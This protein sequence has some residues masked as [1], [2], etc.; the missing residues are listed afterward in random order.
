MT[1][2]AEMSTL[3]QRLAEFEAFFQNKAR[4]QQRAT[5]SKTGLISALRSAADSLRH[6]FTEGITREGLTELFRRETRETLQF[7]TRQ[8]DFA[9]LRSLPWFKRY[10]KALWIIFTA[11]AYRLSP[12]RRIVFAVAAFSFAFG[13]LRMVACR[14]QVIDGP[15]SRVQA[16]SVMG[17]WLLAITLF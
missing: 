2:K 1:F 14:V 10:P 15:I 8:I 4:P 12:P 5:V 6:L 17:W 13:M 16:P 7:F 11:M 9:A 3:R